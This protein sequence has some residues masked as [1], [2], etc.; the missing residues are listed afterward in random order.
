MGAEQS[1]PPPP[2]DG[3]HGEGGLQPARNLLVP[4]VIGSTKS[5]I[6]VCAHRLLDSGPA[7]RG[8]ANS[9]RWVAISHESAPP[10]PGCVAVFG[11]VD[12]VNH[13]GP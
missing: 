11:K 12:V 10:V 2:G 7:R 4:A 8:M 9:A 5:L 13:N 6:V 3:G 1:V